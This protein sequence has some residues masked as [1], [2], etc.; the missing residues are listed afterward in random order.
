[1]PR[2]TELHLQRKD[3]ESK[4]EVRQTFK[5]LQNYSWNEM[6]GIIRIGLTVKCWLVP[7][8]NNVKVFLAIKLCY[9]SNSF[10]RFGIHMFS[11]NFLPILSQNVALQ[12]GASWNLPLKP[13][14]L[15]GTKIITCDV[16]HRV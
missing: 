2:Q 7:V 10:S 11:L 16:F 3:F 13:I 14:Y 4:N 5:W 1:M 6:I 8:C 9:Y 15:P 12:T